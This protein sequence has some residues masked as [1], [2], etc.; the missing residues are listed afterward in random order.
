MI[1][2]FTLIALA[3]LLAACMKRGTNAPDV[4]DVLV[5]RDAIT[6][7][8]YLGIGNG[9]LVERTAPD[10]MTHMGCKGVQQ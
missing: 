1:R 9:G 7:C 4:H 3:A 5:Y 2:A 10:G 8:E 6:G